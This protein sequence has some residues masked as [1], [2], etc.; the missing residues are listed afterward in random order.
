MQK[1]PRRPFGFSFQTNRVFCLLLGQ[2]AF[3]GHKCPLLDAA[4]VDDGDSVVIM[5]GEEGGKSEV[6]EEEALA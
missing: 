6:G 5:G 4:V 3:C 2:R 1:K